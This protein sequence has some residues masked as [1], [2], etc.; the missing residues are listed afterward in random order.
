MCYPPARLLSGLGSHLAVGREQCVAPGENLLGYS[1]LGELFAKHK[2][3]DLAAKPATGFGTVKIAL[4][5]LLDDG[6]RETEFPYGAILIFGKEVVE[7]MEWHSVEDGL[8][9]LTRTIDS[10]LRR[11]DESENRSE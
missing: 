5:Y 4:N 7:V 3:K 9:G 2:L 6:S 11:E 8:M 1:E 10:C